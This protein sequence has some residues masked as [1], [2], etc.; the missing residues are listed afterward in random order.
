MPKKRR[1]RA[2]VARPGDRDRHVADRVLEDQVPADDPGHELAERRVGVGVGA[3][4][5]RD[6]RGQLRVAQAGERADRAEQHEGDDERRARAVADHGAV[7]RDLADRG[8]ADRREDAGADDGADPEHDEVAGAERAL[9]GGPEAP[10]SR[11]AT[12]SATALVRKSVLTPP[13][14][15]AAASARARRA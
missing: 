6:E 12:M 9:E 5:D 8:G 15:A 2:E 3:A 10:D 14:G 4:G 13:P 1:K 11:S 7:G